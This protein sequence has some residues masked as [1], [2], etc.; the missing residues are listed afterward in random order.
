MKHRLAVILPAYTLMYVLC[1]YTAFLVR[2][3]FGLSAEY[4]FLFQTTIP[5]VLLAKLLTSLVTGEWRRSFRYA[6]FADM[7][8][9]A[10]GAT[11]AA[12]LLYIANA[13]FLVGQI[14]NA[15]PRSV[16]LID[17]GLTI[18]AA[19][20]LRSGYR[21]YNEILRSAF[22]S[23]PRQ[24]TLIY[25]SQDEGIAVL[26]AL[27][28]TD[29]EY[30]IVGF[31]GENRRK[32]YSL[33]AGIPVYIARVGWKQLASSLNATHV[34]I[35]G[36]VPGRKIREILQECAEAGLQTHIIP[37]VDEL[38]GGRYEL[39][40]R[41]VTISDLLRRETT[42]LDMTAIRE[43]VTGRRVMVTGGAGSIG[44]E[45]C[46]QI[47]ALGPVSLLIVD[48]SE[49][50]M[51]AIQQ[52]LLGCEAQIQ[53]II[54]DVTD[55]Q[56]LSRVMQAERP[57]LVFHAAAYKHVPLME[58][59]PREAVRNNVG[60]AR[61][62][63]DLSHEFGVERFVLISSD[64]A[65]RP[66][67]VMGSTKLIA[68]K[69]L[70]AVSIQSETRF[71]TVRFGNVLNSV[72]SVVPTFLQQIENGGPV[73]VTHP[74]MRRFFM[75]IPEAV[76]LVLQAG[77]VGESGDLLIL[78]MGEPVRI[79]DLARDLIVLSGRKYPDDID[80]VFT[81]LRPGEKLFEELLYNSE[82]NST[83]VHDKIYCAHRKGW[84]QPADIQRDMALL[85]ESLGDPP[86]ATL[87]VLNRLIENY[88]QADEL[89]QTELKSAA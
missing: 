30:R 5:F 2:F 69:Y 84:V 8:Y 42:R 59:N 9:T 66:S 45:L 32:R 27:Q 63:V 56:T 80:I 20:G 68:E 87:S 6:T 21:F 89:P 13:L 26:R 38:A 36:T 11:V 86:G 78:E 47:L 37:T 67:S 7:L 85:D 62:M 15:V 82:Q 14:E 75:L 74:E 10:V 57:Q 60:G 39:S 52:E 58:D 24:R 46:R 88:V 28:T 55:R 25:Q 29:S 19:G 33:I 53:F 72:G 23:S 70:Q 44:S 83:K 54:A 1:Y 77:A 79:V 3:D 16:I 73:T 49:S 71:I 50:A 18:L 34:L 35:P 48:Q 51:F 76:Q 61:T 40:I 64:K 12:G 65:V 41:H 43:Y 17:W 31:V 81:G 4:Q 22:A